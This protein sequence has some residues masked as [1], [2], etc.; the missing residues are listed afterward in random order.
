M[1]DQ[2]TPDK[3]R[4]CTMHKD[5]VCTMIK[6]YLRVYLCANAQS[7]YNDY[8]KDCVVYLLIVCTFV[9]ALYVQ[10]VCAYTKILYGV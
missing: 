9:R 10:Y 4:W 6:A 2:Y 3:G 1:R 5:I 8:V 7:V